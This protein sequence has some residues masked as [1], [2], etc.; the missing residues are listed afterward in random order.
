MVALSIA[1]ALA[2]F[3]IYTAVAGSGTLTV[4]P[5]E[6]RGRT[7]K[8]QLVGQVV[9]PI[10][11][12]SY[13]PGG[14]RFSLRD[15]GG[16]AAVKVVYTGEKGALFKLGQ[17]ILVTGQLQGGSFVAQRDSMITKCPSKYIPKKSS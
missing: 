11:G 14:L 1:G 9:G 6:L 17:N 4:K 5:S 2:V 3:L 15:I 13:K 12:N 16:K 10:T 7:N 8:L